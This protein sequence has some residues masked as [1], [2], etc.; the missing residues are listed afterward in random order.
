MTF[1]AWKKALP[2]AHIEEM[3]GTFAQN[4]AY[5]SKEGTLTE[6]GQKP[7]DNGKKRSVLVFKERVEK[8][9]RPLD[10]AED[11]EM[12]PTWL[13]NHRA[14]EIYNQ[15]IRK[16][17]KVHDR[18]EPAVYLRVGPP[19]TGKTRWMDEQFGTDGWV[20]APDN[21][22]RWFDGCDRDVICFDDVE[23]GQIPPMA[24]WKKLTDRY[25]GPMPTKGGFIYWKPKVIVVTSNST[26]REWWPDAS[27]FDIGAVERRIKEITVVE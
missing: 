24:T 4:E 16:K 21:T 3:H 19:G 5:C 2:G 27:D 7:M 23:R 12:F 20:F 26:P 11:E 1:S 17:A 22:G 9:E 6:F 14:L 25:G 15:H 13:Q 18:D 10:I 8:G